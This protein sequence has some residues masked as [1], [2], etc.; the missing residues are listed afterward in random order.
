MNSTPPVRLLTLALLSISSFV[1]AHTEPDTTV[2][3]KRVY[4]TQAVLGMDSPQ[5]DGKLDDKAW[6]LVEWTGNYIEN[7]PDENTPPSFQTKFKILYDQKNLYIGVRCYDGEPDK[8][9]KRLSRRDGFEGDWVEF[10]I[11]SYHDQRTAF[12]FTVT[13]AGV[14]G[15]EF[16]S[17]NGNNWDSSW[18]PIWY[19]KTRTDEEGWTAEMRIPLSQIKFGNDRGAGLGF[20][21]HSSFFPSRG[22]FF[23]AKSA[24]GCSWMG[25]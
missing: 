4:T 22:T 24:S 18:N 20:A 13:A 21:I 15:D 23:V 12:S 1:F 5:I 8:I 7:R 9:V 25:E 19:V 16:V 2:V 6:E 3:Q 11:D 14:K 10:N 17:N